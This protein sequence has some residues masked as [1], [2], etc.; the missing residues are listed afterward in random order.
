M[1]DYRDIINFTKIAE[2]GLSSAQT[3]SAKKNPA[4]C[5]NGKNGFPYHTNK[6]IQWITFK[7]LAKKGNYLP[8]CDNFLKMPDNIWL[9]IYKVGYWNEMLGDKIQNQAIANLF[10][11]W[12]WGSGVLGAKNSLIDFFK[13]K[14]NKNFSNINEIVDFVNQINLEDKNQELFNFL[15]E[16]RKDFLIKTGQTN[17]LLG[18]F[19]RENLFYIYNIK[20][21]LSKKTK[22]TMKG[23]IYGSIAVISGSLILYYLS[24]QK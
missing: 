8:T 9:A 19:N 6:G 5:G 16:W 23:L 21:V 7:S 13:K 3:D 24:K 14:Y 22:S 18:W 17:N 12:A 10:V 2:G 15:M 4:P 20:Y 11:Q 1:A